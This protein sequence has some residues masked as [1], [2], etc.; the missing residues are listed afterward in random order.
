MFWTCLQAFQKSDIEKRAEESS[1]VVVLYVVLCVV[2]GIAV[3]QNSLEGFEFFLTRG[4]APT[5][6]QPKKKK[7]LLKFWEFGA[8]GA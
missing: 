4:R 6:N 7:R 2:L 3:T 1:R 8:F 5:K